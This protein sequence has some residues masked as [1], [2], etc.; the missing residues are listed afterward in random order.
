MPWQTNGVMTHLLRQFP[1]FKTI[2]SSA[3]AEAA[4]YRDKYKDQNARVSKCD[5]VQNEIGFS[6]EACWNDD[7]ELVFLKP[8]YKFFFLKALNKKVCTI[9]HRASGAVITNEMIVNQGQSNMNYAL[10]RLDFTPQGA[11]IKQSTECKYWGKDSFLHFSYSMHYKKIQFYDYTIV[12]DSPQCDD[13]VSESCIDNAYSF[14]G[15]V[16]TW[17]SE[18]KK[19]NGLLLSTL[20]EKL[21]TEYQE[22]FF[23]YGGGNFDMRL[24]NAHNINLDVI[25]ITYSV[26]WS[27]GSRQMAPTSRLYVTAREGFSCSGCPKYAQARNLAVASSCGVPQACVTCHAWQRVM[28]DGAKSSCDPPFPLRS[29]V[30][31]GQHENRSSDTELLCAA[32]PALEPMRRVG[33]GIASEY[34]GDFRC[35]QCNHTQ[36]FVK[37]NANGCLYFMSVADG[38]TFTGG[39]L[40]NRA[41]VDQYKPDGSTRAPEAVPARHYRNL[42]PDGSKWD[43]SSIASKCEASKYPDNTYPGINRNVYGYKLRYR[44]WCGHEEMV[45]DNNAELAVLG[46]NKVVAD[47]VLFPSTISLQ[48]LFTFANNIGCFTFANNIECPPYRVLSKERMHSSSNRVAEIK[49]TQGALQCYYEIRREGRTDDCTYCNGTFYTKDCGPTYHASLETPAR[50][51]PGTCEKCEPQCF[52]PEHFFSASEFSCWSNGT[53]RVSGSVSYGSVTS[54][55]E[56]MSTTRNY[57]YKPAACVACR[58]LTDASVPQIV[59]RCGNKATFEVWHPTLETLVLQVSRPSRRVCC[60]IDSIHTVSSAYNSDLGTRCVTEAQ[61]VALDITIL[62]GGA[63]PLCQTF[64]PDLSTASVPFCPPGWFFDTAVGGCD[65]RLEAWSQKCCSRCSLCATAG[66]LKTNQYKLCSGDTA[67]DTQLAGCVTSCAEKNYQV[68]NDSCVECES[69]G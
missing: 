22:A 11:N 12:Q 50:T 26:P 54:I 58:K 43:K 27:G 28:Q 18:S 64:V 62:T 29:C 4:D 21:P 8:R 14:Y 35:T 5:L 55:G 38:L 68:G 16:C 48:G 51:G 15:K 23:A 19:T 44:S 1:A 13:W 10:S 42:M 7:A 36:Y 2:D 40:F 30:D 61:G 60:A 41:Y 20:F 56:A 63:T 6:S 33:T 57:W 17:V 46:C 3:N 9:T 34:N 65:G 24:S 69:C 52:N 67:Q 53:S 31:C 32:C 25:D 37:T 66:A 39:V 49:L 59:T 47:D 45:K